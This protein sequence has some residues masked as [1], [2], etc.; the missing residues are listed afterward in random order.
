[1]AHSLRSLSR[2]K[3]DLNN[4]LLCSHIDRVRKMALVLAREEG[5]AVSLLLPIARVI[6]HPGKCIFRTQISYCVSSQD[7]EIVEVAALLH[8]IQDWKYSGSETA[9][10]DTVQVCSSRAAIW[11]LE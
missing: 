1:M 3:C 4:T 9:S 8:D 11:D 2:R 6:P 7:L 10:A 5:N